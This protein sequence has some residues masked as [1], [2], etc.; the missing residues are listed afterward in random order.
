MLNAGFGKCRHH[1]VVF[2]I[3]VQMAVDLLEHEM[4]KKP[5]SFYHIVTYR[6]FDIFAGVHLTGLRLPGDT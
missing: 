1:V 5:L 3:I 6:P 4:D 2:T